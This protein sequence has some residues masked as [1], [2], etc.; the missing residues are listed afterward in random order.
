MAAAGDLSDDEKRAM[1]GSKFA[2]LPPPPSTSRPQPRMAHPGGPLTTN[3][4]AALA[5]FLERKLQQPD[6]LDSLN[7]DLV[8]LAVKNAKETIKASKG[9]AST[10]GRVIRHVSSFEDGSEDS[11]DEAEVKGIKRKRKNKVKAHQDDE[12]QSKK[13]KKKKKKK[14][15]GC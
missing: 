2:P 13:K 3:K 10:S 12:H 11:E 4:A 15:K 9:E 5:K 1:R 6:G 14:G 8:K 7:P